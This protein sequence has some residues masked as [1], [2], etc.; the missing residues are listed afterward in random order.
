M[1]ISVTEDKITSIQKSG[2][3][4]FSIEEIKMLGD[5]SLEAGQ[6]LRKDLNLLQYLTKIE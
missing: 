3:A 2:A 5:K 1:S 4:T 6:K